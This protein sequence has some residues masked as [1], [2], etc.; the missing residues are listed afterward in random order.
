MFAD[1][2]LLRGKRNRKLLSHS[3]SLPLSQKQSALF[4]SAF[5]IFSVF[6]MSSNRKALDRL[7]SIANHFKDEALEKSE[8]KV[9]KSHE[10]QLIYLY[11]N[12]AVLNRTFCKK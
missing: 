3:L 1:F 8:W 4:V 9:G 5:V 2:F 6:T 10:L 12:A 7:Q 11:N